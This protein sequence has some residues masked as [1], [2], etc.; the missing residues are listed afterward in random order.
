MTFDIEASVSGQEQ[1]P[2]KPRKQGKK[3]EYKSG[4][5]AGL[6]PSLNSRRAQ[7][8]LVIS[9]RDMSQSVLGYFVQPVGDLSTFSCSRSF[10]ACLETYADQWDH[11]T[12]NVFMRSVVRNGH[13]LEF[14]EGK[15]PLSRVPFAFNST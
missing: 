4:G 3:A 12:S 5:K 7:E 10:S 2:N 8:R 15:S 9:S 6:S 13:A 14:A 1:K 11:I